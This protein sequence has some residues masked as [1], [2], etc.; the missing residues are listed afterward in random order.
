VKGS[1]RIRGLV[2]GSISRDLLIT[3]GSTPLQRPGGAVHHGG[4]ALAA[5][6]A[7]VR[8]LTRVN[9]DDA[10]SLLG[11]LRSKGADVL[12]LP[13]CCTTSYVNDY[14]GPVDLHDLKAVSDPIRDEDVPDHWREAEFSQ[15]GPLHA[16]DILPEVA[17][18]LQSLVGLDVQGFFREPGGA[19]ALPAFMPHIDVLQVSQ[20]DLGAM[21]QGEGLEQFLRRFGLEEAIV[22]QGARGATILTP[23][24]RTRIPA[25]PVSGGDLVGSGDVFLASYLLARARGQGPTDAAQ[26]ATQVCAAKITGAK[27]P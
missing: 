25:Q 13:S 23:E 15:L 27:R 8:I 19:D 14:S 17:E 2:V 20:T 10:D 4:L 24:G 1:D 26:Q 3:D 6:G 7:Q 11:P 16:G 18:G 5:L 9:P 22:T 21:L 12:A